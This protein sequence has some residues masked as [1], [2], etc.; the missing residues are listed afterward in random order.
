MMMALAVIPIN[1]ISAETIVENYEV[2]IKIDITDAY[3]YAADDDN[4][5]NDIISFFTLDVKRNSGPMHK[6]VKF[7]LLATLRLPSGQYYD[8]LFMVTSPCNC[9]AAPV[10][11]FSN[12]A[13][14]AGWYTIEL[15]IILLKGNPRTSVGTESFEF[16]PP[17]GSTD[18]SDPLGCS[19]LA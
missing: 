4:V 8:Y 10:L 12:H 1:L 9:H 7:Y 5:E 2:Q 14:E 18:G 11:Y 15:T 17:G 3:Y 13:T 16:D 6:N 19:I